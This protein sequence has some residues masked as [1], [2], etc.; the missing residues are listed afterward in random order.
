MKDLTFVISYNILFFTAYSNAHYGHP[1]NMIK[2]GQGVN[3]GDGW[4]TARRLD[5]PE[6][7]DTN[8]DGTLRVPGK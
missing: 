2:P 8:D 5:R 1:R 4:E 6:V 7:L 3:M